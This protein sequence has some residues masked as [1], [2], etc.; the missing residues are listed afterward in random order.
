MNIDNVLWWK[1]IKV[2]LLHYILTTWVKEG[3]LVYQQ[4]YD[5]SEGV[6]NIA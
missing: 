4:T 2:K 6:S 1:T 3:Y 5:E